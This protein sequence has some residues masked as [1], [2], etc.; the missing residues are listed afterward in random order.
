MILR[1][2]G[3]NP[4]FHLQDPC[5]QGI[6]ALFVVFELF[7]AVLAPEEGSVLLLLQLGVMVIQTMGLGF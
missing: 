4:V 5:T 6:M 1:R 7:H 3:P 2:L